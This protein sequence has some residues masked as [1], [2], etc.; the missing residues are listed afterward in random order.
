MKK[1]IG[2]FALLLVAGCSTSPV[3]VETAAPAKA[4]NVYAYQ[5]K[6]AGPSGSLTVVRDS[7]F[8]GGGCDMGVY[9]DGRLVAR[10]ATKE[11]VTLFL[12][13]GS[14]VVGAG[15]VGAGLCGANTDRR[16]R[17]IS[18]RDGDRLNYRLFTSSNG[19]ID[20]LPTTY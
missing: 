19:D 2:A 5:S 18:I 8:V 15:I 3:S 12:P 1:L 13:V 17:E 9:V 4:A 11:K 7:G 20:L 6:P 14:K 10:I 16:E